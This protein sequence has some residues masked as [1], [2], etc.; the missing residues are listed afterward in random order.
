[1]PAFSL[2]EVAVWIK[3]SH[4]RHSTAKNKQSF[5]AVV[6]RR[7]LCTIFICS[8]LVLSASIGCFCP[9]REIFSPWTASPLLF[10]SSDRTDSIS[11]RRHLCKDWSASCYTVHVTPAELEQ[12]FTREAWIFR[13]L[14]QRLVLSVATLNHFQLVALLTLRWQ[15]GLWQTAPAWSASSDPAY[16]ETLV[17]GW[18]ESAS[19]LWHH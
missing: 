7:A 3:N 2:D 6:A 4:N 9:Q 11:P 8:F 14:F 18:G 1:M 16:W 5:R 19:S 10:A 17:W 12:D 13:P 15:S